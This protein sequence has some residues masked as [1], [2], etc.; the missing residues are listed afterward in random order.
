MPRISLLLVTALMLFCGVAYAGEAKILLEKGTFDFGEIF[1]GQKVEHTFRFQNAGDEPLLIDRVRSSCGCTVALLSSK[2]VAPGDVAELKTT[3]DSNRFGGAVVKTIYLY[4]NDP[5]Q[6]VTELHLRG[7]VKREI[8]LNPARLDLATLAA[9]TVR[10]FDVR[11]I[12]QSPRTIVLSSLQT[13]TSEV[14]AELSSKTLEPGQEAVLKVRV[15]PKTAGARLSGYVLL[16]T[17]SAYLTDLRLPVYGMIAP[18]K[19]P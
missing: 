10:Q 15:K 9:G 7:T 18:A 8:V 5:L 6:Q 14:E 19:G 3:F 16:K 1:E 17:D 12:N 11:L 2:I 4:S 13:T